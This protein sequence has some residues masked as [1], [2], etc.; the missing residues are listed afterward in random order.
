MYN[1]ERYRE[2]PS[3]IR[4]VF[5][6]TITYLPAIR[7][8]SHFVEQRNKPFNKFGETSC[9]HFKGLPSE[10]IYHVPAL[11]YLQ[12]GMI[13]L[14]PARFR[15][16]YGLAMSDW[17]RQNSLNWR[18]L[19]TS[20]EHNLIMMLAEIDESIVSVLTALYKISIG[21]AAYGL[22]PF[23]G[24][25]KAVLKS[26][27]K[28]MEY[29]GDYEDTQSVFHTT[30]DI[31]DAGDLILAKAKIDGDYRLRGTIDMP[32]FPLNQIL[33]WI[34]FHPDLAT[35]WD[36]IPLSFLVNYLFPIGSF[37]ESFREGW[38]KA[39]YFTGFRSFKGTLTVSMRANPD[40][41]PNGGS[42]MYSGQAEIYERAQFADVLQV[43]EWS[44]HP[45]LK[46]L[47]KQAE[48]FGTFA[49]KDVGFKYKR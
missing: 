37:L 42:L 7:S 38:V 49:A 28:V 45:E 9:V 29:K 32:D 40:S 33:D 34:G 47:R 18:K 6:D 13:T 14:D 27:I 16:F 36:L 26:I 19:P 1:R 41:H 25:I 17:G 46:T 11:K 21:H 22:L 23:I 10:Y 3:E 5:N 24:E 44:Y 39:V 20:A 4:Q 43:P 35:A 8:F 12:T 15:R 30:D 2:Q 48:A 31:L